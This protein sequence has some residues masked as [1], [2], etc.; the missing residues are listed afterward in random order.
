MVALA[1]LPRPDDEP[2]NY[3]LTDAERQAP[4]I[5]IDEP[6]FRGIEIFQRMRN[7]R[8]LPVVDAEGVPLGALFDGDIRP[9]LLSP[10]AHSLLRNPAFGAHIERYLRPCP[11]ANA[12]SSIEELIESYRQSHGTEGMILTHRERV[13]GVVSNRR[14]VNLAAE[15]ELKRAQTRLQRAERIEQASRAFEREVAKLSEAMLGLAQNAL[16]NA[17]ATAAR[18]RDT[19]QSAASVA[20]AVG[21]TSA[22]IEA[23]ARQGGDLGNAFE[24]IVGHTCK[25]QMLAG[26]AVRLVEI[27][28]ARAV[29]LAQSADAVDKVIDLINE[30]AAG[31]NLLAIN[32]AIEAARAGHAG[33]GFAVV[34]NEIRLLSRQSENATD[35]IACHVADMHVSVDEVRASHDKVER[36]IADIAA[37]SGEIKS[38]VA[39]QET[40]TRLISNNV[41][42]VV[43][44]TAA[45]RGDTEAIAH[46]ARDAA[47][48]AQDMR[49]L[50]ERFLADATALSAEAES[51][52][53]AV[54]CA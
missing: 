31:I 43:R 2:S 25:A 8:L 40:A 28:S 4:T 35:V 3:W 30:I 15:L 54:R 20:A 42:E 13:C 6:L 49:S 32:A 51:F 39:G 19:E 29:N 50:A 11:V 38:A 41:R 33:R 53:R 34:A 14:L 7:L 48:S 21:Q 27:G 18:A 37:R 24:N 26:D 17:D 23:I 5:G 9:I 22:N 52:M 45:I 12:T 16:K 47:S 36:A 1:T 46:T 44:A 10:F